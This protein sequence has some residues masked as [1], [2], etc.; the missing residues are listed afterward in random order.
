MQN[1][2][3]L[4]WKIP[5][6]YEQTINGLQLLN[7]YLPYNVLPWDWIALKLDLIWKYQLCLIFQHCLFTLYGIN[8]LTQVTIWC[9]Q[10]DSIN[11]LDWIYSKYSKSTFA[12]NKIVTFTLSF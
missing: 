10:R 5:E 8:A 2:F 4:P 6:E 3:L 9:C 1:Y 7:Q 12:V 11:K